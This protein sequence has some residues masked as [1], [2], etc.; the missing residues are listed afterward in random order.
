MST[1]SRKEI[2]QESFLEGQRTGNLNILLTNAMAQQVGM[3]ASDYECYT[4]LKERGALTAGELARACGISTGGLTGLV[5]RLDKL[6]IVER[7]ADP[8]DRRKVVVIEAKIAKLSGPMRQG[9]IALTKLYT[10]KELALL[11]AHSKR[12][13]DVMQ[14]CLQQLAQKNS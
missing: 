13:N 7:I 11:L 2:L 14:D 5:D 3:S 12:V 6:N 4:L 1:L 10:D 8:N 9:F